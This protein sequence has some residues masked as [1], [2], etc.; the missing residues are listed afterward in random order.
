M[1]TAGNLPRSCV[2]YGHCMMIDPATADWLRDIGK[3]ALGWILGLGSTSFTEWHRS[4]KRRRETKTAVSR[5]LRETAYRFLVLV[6][7][8]EGR[9]GTFGR[10]LLEWIRPQIEQYAGPNP[11]DG[12]LSGV[13][14]LLTETDQDLARFANHLQT[15]TPPQFV[16]RFDVPYVT[17]AVP[18]LH[19]CEP[20]YA[21]RVLDVLAHIQMFN[22]ARENGLHYLRLTFVPGLSRE[23]HEKAMWNVTE[24]E[25]Q[26]A[27]RARIIVDKITELEGA[28][29]SRRS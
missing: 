22:E 5:E 8:L 18:Q 7:T 12:L 15:T 2:Q 14:K 3:I 1:V 16:P 11:K 26:M 23:N 4:R 25:T 19:S 17:G 27:R 29:R 9:S 6:Y 28:F 24:M 20:E 21:V 13:E 10:P